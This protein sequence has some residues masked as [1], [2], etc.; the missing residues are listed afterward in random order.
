ML[1]AEPEASFV[2]QSRSGK[3]SVD[4]LARHRG[5]VVAVKGDAGI[6]AD[7][8]FLFAVASARAPVGT[9]VHAGGVL[10]DAVLHNQTAAGIATVFAPKTAGEE[11]VWRRGGGRHPRDAAPGFS[12]VA[13]LIGSSG[14]VNYASANAAMDGSSSRRHAAGY[15][16]V[17]L[18][19][20]PWSGAGMAGRNAAVAVKAARVGVGM[21]SPE[22]GVVALDVTLRAV[23]AA[24]MSAGVVTVCAFAPRPELER[25]DGHP[26]V[27]SAPS[28][29]SSSSLTVVRA[30]VES[31]VAN[32][33]GVDAID[34]DAPLVATGLDSLGAVELANRLSDGFGAAFPSTLAYDHPTV[35]AVA[36]RVA[37]ALG[38][39]GHTMDGTEERGLSRPES[40]VV[41]PLVSDVSRGGERSVFL[42]DAAGR[43]ARAR[44]E[45]SV[46]PETRWN[47]DADARAYHPRFGR[48]LDDIDAFDASVFDASPTEAIAMDPQHRLLCES[49]SE[50]FSRF[51][52][53]DDRVAVY[54]GIV[55]SSYA[56]TFPETAG[57]Y[58]AT[59]QQP[60][61]AVG[62]VSF[63]FGC[64]G[65]AVAVDTACSS[66]LV[67]LRLAFVNL[68]FDARGED[69]RAALV[70]G[71]HLTLSPDQTRLCH[72]AG[73]LS[74]DG[75]CKTLDAAADGYVRGEAAQTTV[76]NVDARSVGDGAALVAVRAAA[77]NQDGR[78]G[79][80][81][82]PRG[83]SQFAVMASA[84]EAAETRGASVGRLQLHGTG[85]ALGDPVE[86]N[87]AR[88]A[89]RER[90]R[91][92]DD[93]P[94]PLVLAAVKS[95]AG[96]GEP[97]AGITALVAAMTQL[98]GEIGVA[99]VAHL[100]RVNP[101]VAEIVSFDA[102]AVPRQ[103]FAPAGVERSSGVSSFAFQGTNA[104]A[105]LRVESTR[106]ARG[107]HAPEFRAFDRAR[108]RPSATPTTLFDVVS[109][110]VASSGA[111]FIAYP[112]DDANARDHV[113][114][115]R[116]ILAGAALMELAHAVAVRA[117]G[118]GRVETATLAAATFAR[119]F[120]FSTEK[121]T[122]A[123]LDVDGVMRVASARKKTR[124]ARFETTST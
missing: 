119:P 95:V 77:A 63:T 11:N 52:F 2:A 122:R 42:S 67:A 18:Q 87:A 4:A 71:A 73:M 40:S 47:V 78:S 12:S 62:R 34:P 57:T 48:F 89:M 22:D 39:R 58:S 1:R 117:L 116:H 35:A 105:L 124:T 100:R 10:S 90:R 86:I 98:A 36:D 70:G 46:V 82:A 85:T 102:F 15:P 72:L 24:R 96:H 7:V 49:A 110:R 111:T 29:R 123:T 114:G 65:P 20:G 118:V 101:H 53:G 41:E 19:W 38:V 66:S 26:E 88:D 108:F 37:A 6:S 97:A 84:L 113:V 61:A 56:L 21:V 8:A 43:A 64:V 74:P 93:R 23:T 32:I 9:V 109:R 107:V 5:R 69:V 120:D 30:E 55:S 44:D 54:V 3:V 51:D 94:T 121:E 28:A 115:G 31:V 13:A 81:T 104:H 99:P 91:R 80:L 25:V 59:G 106:P 45:I 68:R 83:P 60:S 17:S 75:R 50:S 79:S 27:D 16:S 112:W 33:L 103:T 92:G 14:Q 76:A